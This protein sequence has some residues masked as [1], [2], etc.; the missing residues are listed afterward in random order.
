MKKL[1]YIPAI[2]LI[3]AFASCVGS[4]KKGSSLTGQQIESY[5]A[6]YK[7]LREKAPD[8]LTQANSGSMDAQKEGFS[9]FEGITKENGLSYKEFVII[10]A[11]IGAVYSIMQGESFMGAMDKMKT[12]G[13]EQIDDAQKMMQEQLDNP[14]VPEETKVALRQS[15]AEMKAN[16]EKIN[17]EFDKNKAW[18]DP[19]MDATKGITNLFVSKEDVEL[20]KTYFDKITEAYTGGVVPTNFNVAE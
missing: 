10:N 16:K 2:L 12:D 4:A 13:F 8:M 7:A 6:S 11:K 18:A 5:L 17:S 3:S 1:F 20:I 14:E 19:V 15:M 9:N